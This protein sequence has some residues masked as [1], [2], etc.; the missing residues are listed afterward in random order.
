MVPLAIKAAHR[1]IRAVEGAA[2]PTPAGI[3]AEATL[4]VETAE[5]T[6]AEE[7]TAMAESEAVA[8]RLSL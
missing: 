2:E 7:R 3:I 6:T 4:E 8:D 5:R 1:A